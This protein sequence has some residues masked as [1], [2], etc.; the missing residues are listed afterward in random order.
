M[1][2]EPNPSFEVQSAGS[3]VLDIFGRDT[4]GGSRR[5]PTWNDLRPRANPDEMRERAVRAAHCRPQLRFGH[6]DSLMDECVRRPTPGVWA[7]KTTLHRWRVYGERLSSVGLRRYRY[8]HR[9][10]RASWTPASTG[11]TRSWSQPRD[12]I[13]SRVEGVRPTRRTDRKRP[14][15]DGGD[16]P[17]TSAPLRERL[18]ARHRIDKPL[19][20]YAITR[21]CPF[22]A[23]HLRHRLSRTNTPDG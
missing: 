9:G 1:R 10:G 16:R 13:R 7:V 2:I 15:L 22:G 8:P 21:R 4:R 5:A 12:R 17:E 6:R 14:S 18:D 3:L 23:Q 11:A 19:H 20:R